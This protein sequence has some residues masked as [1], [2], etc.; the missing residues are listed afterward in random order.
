MSTIR[1]RRLTADFQKLREY[2]DRHPRLALLSADG[3]PPE[4]YTIEYRI[5]S[6]RQVGEDL[7]EISVHQVEIVLPRD[8]PRTAPQCR[9]LTPV[10]H[11]NI[12]PHAICV[13]DHWSAGEPIW[14]IVAR[15]GEML[16][17]QSYNVKSPLN[18]EAARW[19]EQNADDLPLDKVSML[20]DLAPAAKAS[21][22]AAAHASGSA[23]P[24]RSPEPQSSATRPPPPESP[25]TEDL[26]LA[27]RCPKCSEKYR[28][29]SSMA[30]KRVRCRSC[31]T[32]MAIPSLPGAE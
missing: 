11:P 6:L 12:A 17:Y 18:G 29:P 30:G 25:A 7:R 15:I 9:M 23:A 10:F 24:P 20:V 32:I 13:G 31:Q 16:S 3:E 4:R 21:R 2:I 1:L 26:G 5:R 28:V 22:E 27:L 8:Y 14:S 19:A